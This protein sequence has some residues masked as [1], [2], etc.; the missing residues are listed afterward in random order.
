LIA[1]AC[2]DDVKRDCADVKRGHGRIERCLGSP[3]AKLSEACKDALA[4]AAAGAR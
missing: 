4:Q 2:T 3:L 1:K